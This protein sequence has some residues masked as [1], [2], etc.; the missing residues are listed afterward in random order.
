MEIEMRI[1]EV[2]CILRGDPEDCARCAKK[3]LGTGVEKAVEVPVISAEYPKRVTRVQP[4]GVR[5]RP[6]MRRAWRRAEDAKLREFYSDQENHFS[7]GYV[8]PARMRE[9]ARSLGRTP[10]SVRMRAIKLNLTVKKVGGGERKWR[11]G[12]RKKRR[13]WSPEM[14]KKIG[15]GVRRA[16]ERRRGRLAPPIVG[17]RRPIKRVE[18]KRFPSFRVPSVPLDVVKTTIN[19]LL[20]RKGTLT[21]PQAIVFGISTNE[22]WERFVSETLMYSD[23]IMDYFGMKGSITAVKRG[24][25]ITLSFG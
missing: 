3:M 24:D 25:A 6:K 9:F 13:A 8:V 7:N 19:D 23:R 22:Q 18:G 17:E 15:E 5:H 16:A 14:K 20:L 21:M 4:K 1:G 10:D 12:F 11:T 2:A